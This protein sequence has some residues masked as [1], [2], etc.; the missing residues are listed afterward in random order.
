M[1]TYLLIGWSKEKFMIL[2]NYQRRRVH[3]IQIIITFFL[4]T[5]KKELQKKYQYMCIEKEYGK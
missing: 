3:K 4:L 5:F 1:N 2:S